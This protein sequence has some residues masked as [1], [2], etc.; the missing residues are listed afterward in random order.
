MSGEHP[1]LIVR[2]GLPAVGLVASAIYLGRPNDSSACMCQ[3]LGSPEEELATHDLVFH[4]RVS[5][6]REVIG[7]GPR[8]IVKFDVLEGFRGADAG[9]RV[10]V[11]VTGRG[12]GDCGL[13]NAFDVG[14]EL[15]LFTDSHEPSMSSCSVY[16]GAPD[17]HYDTCS[18]AEPAYP[19]GLTFD[20]VVAALEAASD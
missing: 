7:C 8:Q 17:G 2:I 11:S 14:D 6:V 15:I 9:D 20:E 10:G 5:D 13:A 3:C 16:V 18:T 12:G 1:R 19:D 4:G